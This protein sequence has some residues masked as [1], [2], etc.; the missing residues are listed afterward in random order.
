M[1]WRGDPSGVLEPSQGGQTDPCR[2]GMKGLRRQLV[3]GW[4]A[5]FHRRRHQVS[6]YSADKGC[7]GRHRQRR[8]FLEYGKLLLAWNGAQVTAWI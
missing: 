7:P 4:E 8:D 6:T 5:G 3:Q 2:C 1:S